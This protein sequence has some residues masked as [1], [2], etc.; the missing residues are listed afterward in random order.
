MR[1]VKKFP[2]YLTLN[3]IKADTYLKKEKDNVGREGVD[4]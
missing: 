2:K 4:T 1:K 3:T